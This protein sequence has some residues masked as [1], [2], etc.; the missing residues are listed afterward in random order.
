MRIHRE[1]ATDRETV[2]RL[3]DLDGE[4][5]AVNCFLYLTPASARPY[6]D[7]ARLRVE[8]HDTAKLPQVQLEPVRSRGLSA[9]TVSAA[10]DRYGSRRRRKYSGDLRHGSRCDDPLHGDR[11]E[12]GNVLDPDARVRFGP[13]SDI[14]SKEKT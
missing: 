8:G 14:R 2:V 11:I 7:G 3:H 6:R 12:M 1:R 5:G 10:T 13:E 4:I 9:H